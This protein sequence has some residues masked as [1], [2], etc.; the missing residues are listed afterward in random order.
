[1]AII[2]ELWVEGKDEESLQKLKDHFHDLEHTLLTGSMIR[3]YAGIENND[4]RGVCVSSAQ[5]GK[6]Y[7]IENL[8]DALEAT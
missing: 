1:M 8:K 2:F 5:I 3:F 6:G 4:V 7:G